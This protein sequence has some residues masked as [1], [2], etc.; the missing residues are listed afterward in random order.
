MLAIQNFQQRL[1]RHYPGGL[2]LPPTYRYLYGNPVQPVVPLGPEPR[3]VCLIGAYPPA[4][5]AAIGREVDVPVADGAGPFAATPYFDGRRVRQPAGAWLAERY[6][7]P[8]GLSLEQCWLTYLV[9]LFLFKDEHLARYRRLGCPWP[10]F[11]THSRF[12]PLARQGLAWLA[13]ELALVRPRLVITLGREVAQVLQA[14]PGLAPDETLLGGHLQDLWLE[15]AV[16]PVLHLEHRPEVAHLAQAR[17]A[18]DR[19]LA[20]PQVGLADYQE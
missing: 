18:V 3:P 13:E 9:R 10:E 11:E 6:L 20:G 5:L 8:L 15:E 4:R 14:V 19:L 2:S 17:P 12:S 7:T 1:Y 16:Y